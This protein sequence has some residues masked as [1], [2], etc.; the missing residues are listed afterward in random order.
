MTSVRANRYRARPTDLSAA[1][2]VGELLRRLGLGAFDPDRVTSRT[3]RNDNWSG[4]TTTGARVFVKHLGRPADDADVRRRLANTLAFEELMRRADVPEPLGPRC[5][6]WSEE[7]GL[8]AFELL[9]SARNGAELADD[10]A[11]G[12]PQARGA[13]RL[14]GTLHGLDPTGRVALDPAPAQLPPADELTALS[15]EAHRT[16]SGAA[17][18]AWALLQGDPELVAAIR[19]L[20]EG[21]EEAEACPVHGDFRLDQVLFTDGAPRLVDLEELRRGDPAR[22]LGAYAGEWLFRVVTRLPRGAAS[23]DGT[24]GHGARELSR[25]RPLIVWFRAGYTAAGRSVGADLATRAAAFAGWHLIDRVLARA[26]RA[27]VLSAVDRAALGIGRTVLL[28]PAALTT[29]LGL[30]D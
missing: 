9:A 20:G 25:V 14:L 11:F 24:V 17:L 28:R 8:V 23:G 29:T 1:P 18:Q 5:L 15:L 7:D 30:E 2:G 4:T 21:D 22:D 3:G 10:D 12:E 26:S 16:A 19:A 27:S 6:G 13:G